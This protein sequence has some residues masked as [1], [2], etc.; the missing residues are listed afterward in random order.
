MNLIAFQNENRWRGTRPL[1]KNQDP[2]YGELFRVQ[3]S[4]L[5]VE[6]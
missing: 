5:V 6:D 4:K 2:E 1:R 3:L